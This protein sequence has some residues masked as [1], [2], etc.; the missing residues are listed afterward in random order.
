MTTTT[1]ES[2]TQSAINANRGQL[3]FASMAQDYKHPA[4]LALRKWL[5]ANGVPSTY[6]ARLSF[7]ELENAWNDVSDASL[8]ILRLS[9]GASAS[10]A[11]TA[12]TETAFNI[13]ATKEETATMTNTSTTSA[14]DAVAPLLDFIASRTA[15]AVDAAKVSSIVTEQMDALI[16]LLPDMIKQHAD[17]RTIEIKQHDG[18]TYK[19]EGRVHPKF[20]TLLKVA[21]SRQANGRHPN[22]MLSGPTGSGKTHA[23]EQLA[24]AL[25]LEFYTNGAISMDHQLVG[26]KDA[27]GTYHETPLR[28]AFGAPAVYLFDEIDSSDNSPLLCLAGALA[29]GGFEFPDAFIERHPDSII[30][31]AGNTWGNGATAEFVGR[32]R[33]DGAI[34]S[35]FPVRISWGYD[36]ALE[37]DISGNV[38]WAKR[39][40]KARANAQKAGI[41][42]QIDPRM[43]QAGAAIIAAGMT[44]EEA[45]ELTY[46]AELTPEQ[47]RMVDA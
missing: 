34:K 7:A 37:R 16:S 17:V 14:A 45:A 33:L 25:G 35:R 46:L 11:S 8:N 32:N 27:S 47:R 2:A 43:T 5:S 38:D 6:A 26:F 22:I 1:N 40:Q 29:N 4:K 3:S 19:V 13:P 12:T 9:Q 28:K 18:S 42:V 20:E 39:V 36:E 21:S 41:K 15:G 31:A 10:A 30:I 24:K 44:A 23:I